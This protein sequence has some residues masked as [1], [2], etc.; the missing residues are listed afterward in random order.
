MKMKSQR[1][2]TNTLIPLVFIIIGI[3]PAVLLYDPPATAKSNDSISELVLNK[4][5]E[6]INLTPFVQQLIDPDNRI[7]IK[8][9]S[10]PELSDK[11]KDLETSQFAVVPG[12]I[13]W[14]RFKIQSVPDAGSQLLV[15]GGNFPIIL[16]E[17]DLF[18]KT[19]GEKNET[20]RRF[21]SGAKR[22]E[23]TGAVFDKNVVFQL[24][25][26]LSEDYCYLRFKSDWSV[27]LPLSIE[28]MDAFTKNRLLYYTAFG[29]IY[30]VLLSMLLYNSFIYLFLRDKTYLFYVLYIFFTIAWLLW[31]HGHSG[32]IFGRRLGLDIRFLW[33]FIGGMLFCGIL[34]HRAFLNT[35][36][37]TPEADKALFV[38]MSLG[39]A[40]IL[41]A[42]FSWYKSAFWISHI[43]GLLTPI[44]VLYTAIVGIVK[45]YRPARYFIIAWSCLVVGAISFALMGLRIAP[46]NP[47]TVFSLI[48]GIAFEAIFLSIALA[49]RIRLLQKEK[50]A[51]KISSR[52]FR[53][54]S[55]T[56]SLT[57]LYNRRYL[58]S[59]L[60]S[61]L[62]HSRR[63]MQ[64]LSFIMMD[65][66]N[67][68]AFNDAYGHT[69]GD[70]LLAH[71]AR[72]VKTCARESDSACRYGGEEFAVILP[73]TS[74]DQAL[75]VAERIRDS[76]ASHEFKI[77]ANITV[78]VS[79][80]IGIAEWKKEEDAG[81]LIKRADEALYR[82]KA[83]GKNRCVL[84]R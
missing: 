42:L 76:L 75:I 81:M 84:S 51:F 14:L 24:P 17:V 10:S 40:V 41:C 53:E 65:I 45:G 37:I 71:F 47:F 43:A 48:I 46:V 20:Y 74:E 35:R 22:L 67:F 12:N 61:E 73:G 25:P 15:I 19:V 4:R 31:L 79:V 30:G 2:L 66:D 1:G 64:P 59:K 58:L 78:H 32:L 18:L 62:D 34:F 38:L 3:I 39:L 70:S 21:S 83:D 44:I 36:K 13:Y 54:L 80:S 29:L 28:K 33:I 27:L 69:E 8:E 60:S 49:A 5:C 68:K 63:M 9:A 11:F 23:P 57:G 82:A 7:T 6:R 52:R 56:D 26:N 72:I 50:Q 55:V 16:D 77:G